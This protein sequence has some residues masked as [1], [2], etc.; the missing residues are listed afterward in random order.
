MEP[1]TADQPRSA[2]QLNASPVDFR[3]IMSS[4]V[5]ILVIVIEGR[6]EH[7]LRPVRVAL[8]E[9]VESD[10]RERRGSQQDAALSQINYCRVLKDRFAHLYQFSCVRTASPP[11]SCRPRKPNA[12]FRVMSPLAMGLSF[13]RSSPHTDQQCQIDLNSTQTTLLTDRLIEV[14]VRHVVDSAPGG[15]H[16][17]RADPEQADV[18][19]RGRERSLHGVRR[20]RDR[21]CWGAS[22]R[23]ESFRDGGNSGGREE[24]TAWVEQQKR[25][26]GL[27]YTRKVEI[28]AYFGGCAVDPGLWWRSWSWGAHGRLRRDTTS[29]QE[30]P[31]WP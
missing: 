23:I 28:R 30:A 12:C 2:P 17:Q 22:A 5:Y 8:H 18:R 10:D 19:E 9:R 24:L 25:A 15:A 1:A 31:G 21:P 16:D 20:H 29:T 7:R 11:V 3:A 26:Y 6:T 4:D 27:L 14:L 13:V